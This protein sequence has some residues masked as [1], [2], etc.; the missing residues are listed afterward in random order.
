M[1]K[2]CFFNVVE[3]RTFVKQ[4][5]I[6]HLES[7]LEKE[8]T[9]FLVP[10]KHFYFLYSQPWGLFLDRE[11]CPNANRLHRMLMY[12]TLA[13]G[14]FFILLE[15]LHC[16]LIRW[17]VTASSLIFQPVVV[18]QYV[19]LNLSSPPHLSGNLHTCFR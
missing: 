18:I 15:M 14:M 1:R 7:I 10:V 5:M 2:T 19:I 9:P 8:T 11:I 12:T 13:N 17:A 16:A 6:M 4:R 3:C